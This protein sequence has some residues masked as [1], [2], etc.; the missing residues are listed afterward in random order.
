[1]CGRRLPAAG[2]AFSTSGTNTSRDF[3]RSQ[4]YGALGAGMRPVS[5]GSSSAS[6][7]CGMLFFLSSAVLYGKRMIWRMEK[8]GAAIVSSKAASRIVAC[9][10]HRV[11]ARHTPP[12]AQV[13]LEK[14]IDRVERRSRRSCP[15]ARSAL[16]RFASVGAPRRPDWPAPAR[17][18]R[19]PGHK[20]LWGLAA[21]GAMGQGRPTDRLEG[22]SEAAWRPFARAA[23]HRPPQRSS[24]R[25]APPSARTIDRFAALGRPCALFSVAREPTRSSAKRI[26]HRRDRKLFFSMAV[27]QRV[28]NTRGLLPR[29][30]RP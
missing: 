7:V 18:G 11:V 12:A 3:T 16:R 28:S 9:R 6:R 1:M 26:V 15:P 4:T 2:P 20:S 30:V 27:L 8:A 25:Y 24:R 22:T 10:G 14:R 21:T 29:V 5:C 17:R 23:G 13:L 19:Q